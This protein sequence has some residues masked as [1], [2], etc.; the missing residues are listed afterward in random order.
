MSYT[1]H[2]DTALNSVLV[3]HVRTL[4]LNSLKLAPSSATYSFIHTILIV[5]EGLLGFS[6]WRWACRVLLI[7]GVLHHRHSQ[8]VNGFQ[9]I[10]LATAKAQLIRITD[11]LCCL[12]I[13]LHHSYVWCY[14]TFFF[15]INNSFTFVIVYLSWCQINQRYAQWL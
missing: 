10:Q 4:F 13:Q 6:I 2:T 7:G 15:P 12:E 11:S 8:A 5:S 9:S 1:W 3:V 14:M